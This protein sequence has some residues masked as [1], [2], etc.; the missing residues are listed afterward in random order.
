MGRPGI[1]IMTDAYKAQTLH[2]L[3]AW[4]SPSFP[5]GAFTYSHGLET[6]VEDG[7]VRD[8]PSLT[9]WIEDV[10]RLGAGWTD[11]LIL[12]R[13]WEQAEDIVDL[14]DLA[15]AL[16]PTRERRLEA[17]AQGTAFMKTVQDAW[18]WP[19]S[20]GVALSDGGEI[21][22]PVAVG[23]AAR[24]HDLPLR[25]VLLGYQ[26]AFA[27]NLVSAGVRLVPL[28]QTDGQRALAALEPTIAGLVEEILAADPD[29]LGGIAFAADIASARHESL[30]TR[31][32]R[33]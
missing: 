24:G 25:P 29:D 21:A 28:G 8:L 4:M 23:C 12:R 2:R 16:Q 11:G 7:V 14:N 3:L 33:S 6:M 18:L 27:A 10:M 30:H 20:G 13:A 1:T 31:L 22:Y 26:H 9:L 19:G 5:I 15:L 32:F 17:S